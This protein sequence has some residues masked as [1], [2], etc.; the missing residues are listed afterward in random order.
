MSPDWAVG[1]NLQDGS[2]DAVLELFL[3]LEDA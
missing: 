3:I 1:V 2:L